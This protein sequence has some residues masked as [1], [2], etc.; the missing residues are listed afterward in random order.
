MKTDSKT[1]ITDV[2]DLLPS[3][4]DRTTSERPFP[5]LI[6]Q[7]FCHPKVT[8]NLS[9]QHILDYLA[10]AKARTIKELPGLFQ[11]VQ[12]GNDP[13]DDLI[14]THLPNVAQR[15]ITQSHA[16]DLAFFMLQAC[17]HAVERRAKRKGTKLSEDFEAMHKRVGRLVFAELS[18]FVANI[19]GTP[20]IDKEN[21]LIWLSLGDVIWTIDGRHRLVGAELLNGWLKDTLRT[22]KYKKNGLYHPSDHD[23]V[24]AEE[25]DVL[26]MVLA[27]FRRSEVTIQVNLDLNIYEERSCFYYLNNF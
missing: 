23:Q 24:T 3:D 17:F 27:E 26:E 2:D 15:E 12:E 4:D 19:R 5:A 20:R 11:H 10:V 9:M 7:Q 8:I 25:I 16:R 21:S 13:A 14:T 22:R 1:V 6:T 18:P